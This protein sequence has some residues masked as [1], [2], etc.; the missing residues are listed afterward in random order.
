MLGCAM[1]RAPFPWEILLQP[2]MLNGMRDLC[3]ADQALKVIL[4]SIAIKTMW[5][6]K[7]AALYMQV[8][9]GLN[10]NPL[11]SWVALNFIPKLPSQAIFGTFLFGTIFPLVFYGCFMW[12]K[13]LDEYLEPGFPAASLQW[14]TH[15]QPMND[16][17]DGICIELW[18]VESSNW[19]VFKAQFPATSL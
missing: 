14:L 9:K 10:V 12:C 5:T 15:G 1:N 8:Q 2:R 19:D 17:T 16:A 6:T 18:V 3:S 13:A 11:F 4:L 7:P